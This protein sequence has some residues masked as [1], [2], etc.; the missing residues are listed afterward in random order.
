MDIIIILAAFLIGAI[1]SYFFVNR[2]AQTQQNLLRNELETL[3]EQGF[4]IHEQKSRLEEKLLAQDKDLLRLNE[5]LRTQ[6]SRAIDFQSRFS[7]QNERNQEL[8]KQI[9]SLKLDLDSSKEIHLTNV[10]KLQ[11]YASSL[12]TFKSENDNLLLRLEEQK[13]QFELNKE[14]VKNEIQLLSNTILEEKSK[15]FSEQNSAQLKQILEPLGLRIDEF[16][17]KVEDTYSEENK[18]RATLKEQI[19]QMSELNQK[20][21][22]EAQ[23]LTKALKGDSKT[24]GNWGEVILERILEKSGL[25]KGFEF[26]VQ[27]TE[28]NEENKMIRPDVV[29]NLPD[30]KF[31]IIDSKVSLTA[32]EQFVNAETD[33]ARKQFIKLHLVSLKSHIKGLADKNYQQLYGN[34]SPDF[35]LLFIPIQ[36]AFDVA[37][38]NEPELYNFAFEQNIILVS[39]T[40]LLATLSTVSSVWKQEYQNRH[41]VEIAEKSGRMYDKFVGF[42]D[43]L[44]K[45]GKSL[46]STQKAYDDALGK[47]STG[48]GNLVNQAETLRELGVKTSKSLNE[49]LI[50]NSYSDSENTDS[51]A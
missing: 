50:E 2:T 18:E 17:K 43:D 37:M 13:T 45:I 42:V 44:E 22:V 35:V 9:N 26:E 28:R 19:R 34:K 48:R 46:S 12:A 38:M 27:V 31:M 11:N 47:L 5:D 29:V 4:L 1:L 30:E 7:G 40:T 49:K 41:A 36:P 39:P 32:Y 3:K 33:E 24:Q 16:K 10:E 14:Q 15:K 25:R 8:E 20:M 51:K 23:N 21:S 6:T